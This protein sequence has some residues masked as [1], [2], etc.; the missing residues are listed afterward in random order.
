VCSV[1]RAV[2]DAVA[3]PKINYEIHGNT[4]P[5]LHLHVFPR[6]PGDP[7]TAGPINA[8]S[9]NDG[10]G[11]ARKKSTAGAVRTIQSATEIVAELAAGVPMPT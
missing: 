7:F 2:R 5:H 8:I 6:Y 1:A 9:T 3:S 4:I 11:S 10:S